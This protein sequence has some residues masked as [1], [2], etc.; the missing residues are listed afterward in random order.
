MPRI[1]D[2]S[3]LASGLASVLP[4]GGLT[5]VQA[6]SGK[7][8]V[9]AQA[10]RAAGDHLGAMT[11][12]GIFVPGLNRNDYLANPACRVKTFFMTPE[13]KKA[14]AAVEFLP[15]CY[16]DILTHLRAAPIAAALV[17]VS[18][19]D[20]EGMCSFGPIVDFLPDLWQKIP[21]LIAHVNPLL[22]RAAGH[23]GIP[24]EKFTA[25]IHAEQKLL[26]QAEEAPDA[27]ALEIGRHVATFVTDGATLQVGLG[28][29]PGA[30][31]RSL[32]TRRGL[33][34]HSGLVSE[35]VLDLLEA[36]A[37]AEGV[38]VTGGV[39]IGGQRLYDAVSSPAFEFRPVSHTHNTSVIAG[40]HH[41][42]TIN[43]AL[44][45]DLFGQA[46]GEVGPRGLMSGPGGASDFARGAKAGGGLRIVALPAAAEG[47]AKSRIVAPGCG[48]GPVSLG[49]MDI[50][51]VV[52]EHGAADLRGLGHHA[53][54]QQLIAIASPDHRET[55]QAAW[56]KT[57]AIMEL[58]SRK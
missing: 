17:M 13:L 55:L 48:V 52:T 4:P 58:G 28:K 51:V 50:D 57:A 21:A 10:V 6:C 36:G 46:Y 15:L 11:F 20:D 16:A 19:P 24:H 22:P 40:L 9:L 44:D 47:G 38:A 26:G 18:P 34:I 53:R 3:S 33:R 25:V 31:L 23:P 5:Y 8:S 43:S 45:V 27:E 35:S 49:R 30:V 29:I 41:F 2:R 37:L 32:T 1:L 39:A 54:A 42:V 14:G 12:T 56:Q 7:S